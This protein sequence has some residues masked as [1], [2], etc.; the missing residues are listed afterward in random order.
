MELELAHIWWSNPTL[1]FT[2]LGMCW[3]PNLNCT[4]LCFAVPLLDHTVPNYTS[5][6]LAS[7]QHPILLYHSTTLVPHHNT[8]YQCAQCD[9]E[10]NFSILLHSAT[11]GFTGIWWGPRTRISISKPL[12]GIVPPL[13]LILLSIILAK[14][15][16]LGQ[17]WQHWFTTDIPKVCALRSVVGSKSV[18]RIWQRVVW[19]R[20]RRVGK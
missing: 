14:S 12:C 7:T 11:L 8:F 3:A 13:N 18:R 9:K 1:G 16:N 5:L 20:W 2:G 15:Q 19:I 4:T 6:Y 10:T 17:D